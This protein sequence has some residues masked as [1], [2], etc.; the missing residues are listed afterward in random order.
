MGMVNC[1]RSISGTPP[2]LY[3]LRKHKVATIHEG[4]FTMALA[5][6]LRTPDSAIIRK[7]ENLYKVFTFYHCSIT[8]VQQL[9]SNNEAF[10]SNM[11]AIWD[12][13][14]PYVRRYGNTVPAVFEPIQ[15]VK[16]LKGGNILFLRCS[17]LLQW[18]KGQPSLL[19]G[20][21][22]YRRSVLCTQL[23][24]ELT[25]HLLLIKPNQL[26]HPSKSVT[27]TVLPFGVRILSVYITE[28]Q[29]RHLST[30]LEPLPKP[31]PSVQAKQLEGIFCTPPA[32]PTEVPGSEDQSSSSQPTLKRTRRLFSNFTGMLEG[33]VVESLWPSSS[34]LDSVGQRSGSSLGDAERDRGKV[35]SPSLIQDGK[36]DVV[37]E[38]GSS[39]D[40]VRMLQ[41]DR[42]SPDKD[43]M[44]IVPPGGLMDSDAQETKDVPASQHKHSGFPD[45]ST[46]SQK[47]QTRTLM[48]GEPPANNYLASAE[49]QAKT[50]VG[51]EEMA[52]SNG[53]VCTDDGKQSLTEKSRLIERVSETEK[54]KGVSL[55][56]K[57]DSDSAQ[58]VRA[59]PTVDARDTSVESS[60]GRDLTEQIL[61]KG[62]DP[63]GQPSKDLKSTSNAS[64][65]KSE[66]PESGIEDCLAPRSHDD[67]SGL[68]NIN[69]EKDQG[70]EEAVDDGRSRHNETVD[71]I[72]AGEAPL[73]DGECQESALCKEEKPAGNTAPHVVEKAKNTINATRDQHLNDYHLDGLETCSGTYC[74]SGNLSLVLS[75]HDTA[76]MQSNTRQSVARLNNEFDTGGEKILASIA[77]KSISSTEHERT[78]GAS[79]RDQS[80]LLEVPEPEGDILESSKHEQE[81]YTAEDL[82]M[83]DLEDINSNVKLE[84]TECLM[85]ESS[86]GTVDNGAIGDVEVEGKVEEVGLLTSQQK[87]EISSDEDDRTLLASDEEIEA[88]SLKGQLS[89]NT[90]N[91]SNSEGSPY[92]AAA[93]TVNSFPCTDVDSP[94]ESEK[95]TLQDPPTSVEE[96]E[97]FTDVQTFKEKPA[98][99]TE[100]KGTGVEEP[101]WDKESLTMSEVSDHKKMESERQLNASSSPTCLGIRNK[102]DS[103]KEGNERRGDADEEIRDARQVDMDK[104]SQDQTAGK[105]RE[106]LLNISSS[107]PV[108]GTVGDVSLKEHGDEMRGC[109]PDQPDGG[110]QEAVGERLEGDAAERRSSIDADFSAMERDTE[111][112][113]GLVN[114][115]LYVQA[116]SDTTLLFLAEKSITKEKETLFQLWQSVLRELGELELQLKNVV[117]PEQELDCKGAY[118]FIHYDSHQQSL[119][120]SIT[121]PVNQAES[122]FCRGTEQIHEQFLSD[123]TLTDVTLRNHQTVIHGHQNGCHQTFY[124]KNCKPIPSPGIPSRDDAGFYIQH[125]SKEAIKE[126]SINLL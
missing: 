66:S 59:Q 70:F 87:A 74:G 77:E 1:M 78:S 6:K 71:V 2:K 110:G 68:G 43:L 98:G 121:N 90:D 114:V 28:Q 122:V 89:L 75:R 73:R 84:G 14:V 13:Y 65:Q 91:K 5:C 50:D 3:K 88:V 26:H 10:L 104:P 19:A 11:A 72:S 80:L 82:G 32:S 96:S 118:N 62:H 24:P 109:A 51:H 113:H 123:E 95:E 60:W 112:M 56:R 23:S 106:M 34:K 55:E 40:V 45:S 44:R 16:L 12:F 102:D 27:D 49:V 38:L 101:R 120:G 18:L 17:H 46:E 100:Y 85:T 54:Q 58:D 37:V 93:E 7:L 9:S 76:A 92:T 69:G 4:N 94:K 115:S 79:H 57:A 63:L 61:S 29:Y 97:S 36:D 107:S 22:L 64:E 117:R 116:H 42:D 83:G 48:L 20:C 15:Q 103:P 124:H 99:E 33:P 35:G 25:S 31:R 30:P 67:F 119:E 52:L 39:D 81:E 111:A 41:G 53:T 108:I 125:S 126:H 47:S 105:E 86:S 8:R 21:I